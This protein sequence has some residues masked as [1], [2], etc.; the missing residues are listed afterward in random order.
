MFMGA[1]GHK[2]MGS[3]NGH[4]MNHH[5]VYHDPKGNIY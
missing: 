5:G 3:W 1:K 4:E 2:Y